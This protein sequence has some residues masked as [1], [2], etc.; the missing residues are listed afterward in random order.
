MPRSTERN[1]GF[2]KLRDLFAAI[3]LFEVKQ[4]NGSGTWIRDKRK[5]KSA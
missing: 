4:K 3:D 1:F 2:K 5:V